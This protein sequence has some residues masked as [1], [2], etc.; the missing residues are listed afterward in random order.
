MN[1]ISIPNSILDK[2]SFAIEKYKLIS[3]FEKIVVAFSAGKD[4]TCLMYALKEL[5]VDFILAHVDMG[6][7]KE[8]ESYVLK[9]MQSFKLP[10]VVLAARNNGV[11]ES[12]KNKYAKYEINKTT[13]RIDDTLFL[14]NSDIN[15]C[16]DCY[17]VKSLLLMEFAFSKDIR[18]IVFGHHGTDSIVSLLK[19]TFYYIDR[20][21]GN[22]IRFNR[23]NF[24]SLIFKHKEEFIN[25]EA[26]LGSSLYE[27]LSYYSKACIVTTNEPPR[28]IID[29]MGRQFSFVRPLFEIFEKDITDCYDKYCDLAIV[30]DCGRLVSA[31]YQTPR[32]M[33]HRRIIETIS[34]R[35]TYNE[36]SNILL[37]LCK[38][39]LSDDGQLYCGPKTNREYKY[40]NLVK[41]K[42]YSKA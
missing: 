37:K 30:A 21:V 38:E 19:S 9:Q 6:F 8:W 23:K 16:S 40:Y 1:Y 42:P 12:W 25:S 2:V 3:P 18:T 29:Y 26:F 17:R 7:N 4:S 14:V 36:I 31:E 33:V 5:E 34:I 15:P 39:K 20:W 11:F 28:N 22:N 35:E 10:F 41:S 24:E 32:E 13:D 27:S